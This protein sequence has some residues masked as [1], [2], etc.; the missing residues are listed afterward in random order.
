MK[1]NRNEGSIE[2]A[3]VAPKLKDYESMEMVQIS[4]KVSNEERSLLME[5]RECKVT[6]ILHVLTIRRKITLAN[7]VGIGLM[8]SVGLTTN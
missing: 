5:S 8:S 4:Y 3:L 1:A 6:N 7:T 2:N